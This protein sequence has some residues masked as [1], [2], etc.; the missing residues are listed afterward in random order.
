MDIWFDMISLLKLED[1]VA[2]SPAFCRMLNGSCLRRMLSRT[3][4]CGTNICNKRSTACRIKRRLAVCRGLQEASDWDFS[5][6][7]AALLHV[8]WA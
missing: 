4:S 8:M 1:V 6:E 3:H 5:I 2:T 7:S